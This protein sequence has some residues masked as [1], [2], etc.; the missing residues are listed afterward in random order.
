M[1]VKSPGILAPTPTSPLALTCQI[2]VPG[3]HIEMHKHLL[4]YLLN[5]RMC[6]R[7]RGGDRRK[8]GGAPGGFT[9]TVMGR[10]RARSAGEEGLDHR[11]EGMACQEAVT[12]F[13]AHLGT[14]P[15]LSHKLATS[16]H[17]RPLQPVWNAPPSPYLRIQPRCR[18]LGGTRTG[19]P[20]STAPCVVPQ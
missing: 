5:Q 17:T 16:S 13:L 8:G 11:A 7:I 1:A 3:S 14:W 15:D 12:D 19:Y 4:K 18:L 2:L 10:S 9:V 6:G 20:F